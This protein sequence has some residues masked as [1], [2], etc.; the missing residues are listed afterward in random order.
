[1]QDTYEKA[2]QGHVFANCHKLSEQDKQKLDAQASGLD[3][4][5]VNQLFEN[6]IV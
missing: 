6:L 4:N 1:M 5:T 3:V 2:G